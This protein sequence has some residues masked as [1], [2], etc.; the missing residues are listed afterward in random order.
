MER[1]KRV[2]VPKFSLEG[3][4]EARQG[5]SRL[6]QL[7]FDEDDNV[8]DVVDEE[9][10]SNIVEERRKAADFVVDDEGLGYVD[11]GEEIVGVGEDRYD[12]KK[13]LKEAAKAEDAKM[14]K[15]ARRLVEDYNP[16]NTLLRHLQ[17]GT[18]N[19]PKLTS[20]TTAPQTMLDIDALLGGG[21]GASVKVEGSRLGVK[22]LIP[23][24]LPLPGRPPLPSVKR[25]A[26]PPSM[27][28][29]GGGRSFASSS[30]SQSFDH[31][32]EGMDLAEDN[33]A[34]VEETQPLP[35]SPQSD[36]IHQ[37]TK[38]SKAS[39]LEG[40]SSSEPVPSPSAP[41]TASHEEPAKLSLTKTSKSL[42][43]A[44]AAAAL[45][46]PQQTPAEDLKPLLAQSTGTGATLSFHDEAPTATEVGQKID[47]KSWIQDNETEGGDSYVKMFWM[48]ATEINGV[49][50]LFGRV[51]VTGAD[52]KIKNY[53]SA[54]A[55]VQGCERNLFVLP[56]QVPGRFKENGSPL[57]VGMA[58]VYNELSHL[59]VPAVIPKQE[60]RSFR[61]KPV[62]RRYAFEYEDIPREETEYMK[63][64]YSA[65]YG[66][67]SLQQC[68]EGKTY[69][70]IFGAGLSPLELFLL[71]RQ[72]QGPGWIKIQRP[73]PNTDYVSWCKV[74]FTVESPK[75]VT[76]LSPT[77][78]PPNPPLTT[79][80]ISLKTVSMV[81]VRQK[82]QHNI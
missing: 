32:D 1:E 46:T 29:L 11:N 10:Y 70:R 53:V 56:R 30:P 31:S 33:Q 75:L 12:V 54:C 16:K 64:V 82:C 15:K 7:T 81:M 35:H 78:A 69:E 79:M 47:P 45:K 26:L 44:A 37:S 40:P 76:K 4:K 58:E 2:K 28:G 63:V 59:L 18:M 60:G 55:V 73:R 42:K 5:V 51:P 77:D 9:K 48:D 68:Q 52:G 72:L 13:R 22:A 17:P 36:E 71:K 67:P 25:P 14:A 20:K 74:E 34:W 41:I 6:D 8:Y 50:Y 19:A 43:L 62:K 24:G 61:C 3:L 57:R 66:I 49:V 21:G 23:G 65:K 39:S 80:C 38:Q 27:M